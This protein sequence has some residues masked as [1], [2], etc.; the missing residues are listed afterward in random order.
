MP[1]EDSYIRK[2]LDTAVIMHHQLSHIINQ[3]IPITT[4]DIQHVPHHHQEQ[5]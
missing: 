5:V 3:E 1:F 4:N 2:Q